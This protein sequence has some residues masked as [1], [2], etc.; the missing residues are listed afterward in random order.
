MNLAMVTC[1]FNPGGFHQ[2][3]RN[4]LRFVR[5]ME[6]EGVPVY[7]AELAYDCDDWVL[8]EVPSVLRLRT[9]RCNVMWHKENLL[10]LVE[11]IV[12]AEFDAIAW[13][14]ADIWFERLDWYEAICEALVN[15]CVVQLFDTV[16]TTGDDGRAVSAMAG[17]AARKELAPGTT[18]SGYGWAARRTLWTEGGRLHDRAIIGGGDVVNASAWIPYDRESFRWLNDPNAEAS[19]ERQRRWF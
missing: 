12:P 6:S 4:Y 13:V 16:V 5:Q 11:E 3:R 19:L 8:P 9:D 15:H 2:S 7:V 18:S 10:N 17:A 14:D 1:H